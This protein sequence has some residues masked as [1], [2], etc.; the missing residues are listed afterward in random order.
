M[1]RVEFISDLDECHK[2]WN[3]LM[4]TELVSDLW[5]VRA[6]FHNQYRHA[7][8]FVV[9]REGDQIT[10][11]LPLSFNE[12]TGSYNYFPGETWEGKT[13]LEQNRVIAKDRA[14]FE[15]MLA[16]LDAPYQL[17]YL[18]ADGV[19]HTANE[20][21]DEIGY[22]FLPEQYNFQV[23]NY[24][25]AF[26]HKTAKRLKKEL[27]AWNRFDLEWRFDEANDFELLC[28][29][30]RSRYGRLSYFNDDRFLN[31]FYALV[32]LLGQRG[33]MRLVTILVDGEPAAVDM[34]SL[35]NGM[36]TMLAGGTNSNF[37]GIAKLINMH[38][39]TYACEQRLD[40][41]DFLCGDF[42]WKPQFHLTPASLYMV[43]GEPSHSE[44]RI[45]APAHSELRF[46]PRGTVMGASNA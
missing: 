25:Q 46:E 29:M 6:C 35:F 19:W 1:R 16:G 22:L 32:D 44:E 37:P 2:L 23:E 7:L 39:L 17:R 45:L 9:A 15:A 27:E 24:M 40:S 42:N 38:H 5:E 14:T 43:E 11:F 30:N 10:G 34:G 36:L 12:E 33:L 8:R 28:Q 26:S 21:V 4:P 13:W 41:V 18:R 3:Q 20:R 31:S